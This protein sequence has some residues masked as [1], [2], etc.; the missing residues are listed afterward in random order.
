MHILLFLAINHIHI[1]DLHPFNQA[2][3]KL[4]RQFFRPC[5]ASDQAKE[6]A[7]VKADDGSPQDSSRSD[8]IHVEDVTYERKK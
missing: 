3:Y 8:H 1:T 5:E 6:I 7:Q 2:A 4:S